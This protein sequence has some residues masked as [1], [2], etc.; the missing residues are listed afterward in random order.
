VAGE[1]H[2][3]SVAGLCR[4]CEEDLEA[5]RAVCRICDSRDL[6]GYEARQQERALGKAVSR[7]WK[8]GVFIPVGQ[9]M[10]R[11]PFRTWVNRE[12]PSLADIHRR[13]LA[14]EAGQWTPSA[15]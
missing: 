8:M 11:E 9:R 4:P 13:R 12:F 3:F 2:R 5:D 6:T 14:S 15:R 1:S 7:A 10:E